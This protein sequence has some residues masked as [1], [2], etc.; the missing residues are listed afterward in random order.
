MW[1]SS[2]A[3]CY[4]PFFFLMLWVFVPGGEPWLV[5]GGDVLVWFSVLLCCGSLV[6]AVVCS[7]GGPL[8]PRPPASFLLSIFVVPASPGLVACLFPG[9]AVC[10]RVRGVLS[11]GQ[12]VAVWL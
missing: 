10:P 3:A 9:R 11:S 4:L 7:G 8:D 5:A 6:V 12:P 2:L 1:W